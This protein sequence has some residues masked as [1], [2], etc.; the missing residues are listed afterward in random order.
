MNVKKL[1]QV[2]LGFD[3]NH[4]VYVVQVMGLTDQRGLQYHG[5]SLKEIFPRVK[6]AILQKAQEIRKFPLPEESRILAPNGAKM[7][8]QP[9]SRS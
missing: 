6:R 9:V 7:M 3:P 5:K 1:M 2:D 8:I 4:E